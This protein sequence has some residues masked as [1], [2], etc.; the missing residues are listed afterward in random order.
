MADDADE[1]KRAEEARERAA[2]FEVPAIHVNRFYLV[3]GAQGTVRIAFGE[4]DATGDPL[5]RTAISA[6]AHDVVEFIDLLSA[7]VRKHP[8]GSIELGRAGGQTIVIQVRQR[9]E[10]DDIDGD[11]SG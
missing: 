3:L 7:F 11:V 9:V 1:Q 2:S 4:K 6:A 10:G 5:F 8:D